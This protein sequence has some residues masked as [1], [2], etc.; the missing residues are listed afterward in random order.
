M[1]RHAQK[2]AFFLQAMKET[3][4]QPIQELAAVSKSQ[5]EFFTTQNQALQNLLQS[6]PS[7]QHIPQS[8]PHVPTNLDFATSN[9][10][11]AANST[12]PE[13]GK[14][15]ENLNQFIAS[16]PSVNE[17]KEVP[18][19]SQ[20]EL[21]LLTSVFTVGKGQVD[22]QLLKRHCE[23]AQIA[24]PAKLSRQITS[25]QVKDL[26]YSLALEAWDPKQP[27]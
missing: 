21:D 17:D 3:I 2:N 6:K 16:V 20:Q 1:Q 26:I 9:S 15:L 7:P 12:T 27:Y 4:A 19:V 8:S 13:L 5:V 10:A 22:S 14:V 25:W 24:F 23:K 11:P 18:L